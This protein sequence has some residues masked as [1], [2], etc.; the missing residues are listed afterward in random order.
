MARRGFKKLKERGIPAVP[1]CGIK[2]HGEARN[3]E[4]SFFQGEAA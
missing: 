4:R 3:S 2:I 1:H